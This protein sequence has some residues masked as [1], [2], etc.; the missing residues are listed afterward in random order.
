MEAVQDDRIY[1]GQK[2]FFHVSDDIC[3]SL[4]D[5]GETSESGGKQDL[6]GD[7]AVSDYA[8]YDHVGFSGGIYG[9][10]LEGAFVGHRGSRRL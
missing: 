1:F 8:V 4:S 9:T 6:V 10:D 5:K 3:R 7:Y 2:D